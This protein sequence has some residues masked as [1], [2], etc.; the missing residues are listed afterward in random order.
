MKHQVVI[1]GSGLGGLLTAVL[2]AKEGFDVAVLEQNK[3]IGGCLQSFSFDKKIF[4]SAV[5][6]IGSLNEGEV[7]HRIFNY[8]GIQQHLQLQRLDMDCFDQIISGA[9]DKSY[10]LAQNVDHF[11]EQLNSYFP[12]EQ[13][14]IKEYAR[15]LQY[16]C[17]H[18]PL[19]NL[20]MGDASEK[21]K[22]SDW[23]LS[24]VLQETK[25]SPAL[26][27]ALTGN[28]ILYAGRQDKTPFYQHALV[29]KS[30]IDSSW[31]CTGGSGQISKQLWKQL[32]AYGG[33]IYRH[34]QVKEL[35]V[36]NGKIEKAV[37][38]SGAEYLADHF[39]SNIA[40]Q[41]TIAL[42]SDQAILK[43]VFRNRIQQAPLTVGSIMV[44][45]VL[46]P[47]QVS[48]KNYNINWNKTNSLEAIDLLS[49]EFPVN[50]SI[51]YTE[52]R[53]HPGYA[54][55]V[56]ILSYINTDAFE[57]WQDTYNNTLAPSGR[58]DAYQEF[59]ASLA[60][61][62]MN[63][64][65]QRYPELKQHA[66]SSKVATPLSYRDYQGSMKGELYGIEKDVNMLNQSSLTTKTRIPNLYLTG[67]N[68]NL[69][70]VLG[71]SMT[72]ISSTADF[73]GMEYLLDKINKA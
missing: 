57:A 5:H 27:Q 26:Q 58:D 50:Y 45:I 1:I 67:Q 52:D 14:A 63:V 8:A 61:T 55:S 36:Q 47:Q 73:V 65:A 3:Q 46:Q 12:K 68:V 21:H 28:A 39:I 66:K 15:L 60:D 16:T 72:A 7:L 4:D 35:T 6:Y 10:A 31:R 29:S 38:T 70:G 25:A 24:S 13:A 20:R 9:D 18:F 37:C 56:S 40:P 22:V 49:Q 71:V 41:Q 34:E 30:Y 69:H 59:K 62:L 44:N 48:Y 11:T 2:L 42:L 51:Y 53:Q 33:T 32:M 19:Y 43:P 54:E 17:D 64:V 23:K